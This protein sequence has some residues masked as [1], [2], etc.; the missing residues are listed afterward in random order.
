[1]NAPRPTGF[2]GSV[3]VAA[4]KRFSID[5]TFVDRIKSRLVGVLLAGAVLLSLQSVAN[6][7][8]VWTK[9]VG[10]SNVPL[11]EGFGAGGVLNT[12]NTSIQSLVAYNGFLYA[13][14][15][16]VSNQPTIWRS[17]DLINWTNVVSS[18]HV[19]MRNIFD[20]QSNTN[21]IFFGTGYGRSPAGAQVWKSTDGVNW[22]AFSTAASGFYE[23][24]FN[25]MVSL[26][27]SKLY[28]GIVSPTNNAS[29]EVWERP[30]N[31][32]ASW[33]K[34]LD[35]NTGL[36]S[37]DGV[38]TNVGL[39]FIYAPPGATNAVFLPCNNGAITN[40]WIYETSDGGA[41]W[42]KNV[43]AGTCFGDKYNAYITC[44]IEF[45]GYLYVGT[46]NPAEGAQIWRT[47]LANATNWSSTTS[48]QQVAS[49]GLVNKTN[50]E[51]HRFAVAYGNLWTYL[52][53]NGPRGQVWRTADGINWV[54]SNVDGFGTTDCSMVGALASFTNTSG[55]AEMVCGAEWISST[56]SK[57][58]ASQ[59]WATQITSG[60]APTITNQPQSLIVTNGDPACFT[61][62]AGSADPLTYQWQKNGTSLTDGGNIFGSLSNT[63]TLR[64]TT[65]NDA[66][67]YDV[68]AANAYGS[69]TSSVATL[70]VIL[71]APVSFT[72][73]LV[74]SGN[75][76]TSL[77]N[78]PITTIPVAANCTTQIVYTAAD[79]YR[80]NSL[81]S[82]G[83]PVTA[84]SGT[85]IFTQALVNISADVSNNAVF[86]LATSAQTGFTNV[87]TTW[88]TNWPEAAV[89]AGSGDGLS[90]PFKYLLGLDPT[91]SNTYALAVDRLQVNNSNVVIS[92]K[93]T[94]SGT[95]S[96]DGMHGY[97]TLQATPALETAFT[98]LANTVV[99]G[100]TVFDGTGHKVYTNA[101]DA[102]NRFFK[103]VVE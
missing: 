48:W 57:I 10:N 72:L 20:M 93:R 32:S 63:L 79:W 7:T 91:V 13:A 100:V 56:N 95:L 27:G 45:N 86:K 24:N 46:G 52:A 51:F 70:T 5:K 43:A 12:N 16:T 22:S 101:I 34:L 9:M 17:S 81:A 49:G 8:D 89:Y 98:N 102:S 66:G 90:V 53:A 6:G 103:A 67:N 87:P 75:G 11:G 76:G 58:N 15:E 2:C 37:A 80:I 97:L 38:L 19:N 59:V 44:I 28:T 68:I 65:T 39:S 31:G 33:T 78:S 4:R 42:H 47:P 64:S 36:G 14:V 71:P 96:P 99:T 77:G 30:A 85:R 41:T 94:V 18:F 74:Q 35:F 23:T 40:C 1:M 61:V 21:G 88:L 73:T 92:L 26:Q 83:V 82:N 54:Q 60:I 50:G 55:N 69:V 84:A 3:P 25:L 29:A 62:G